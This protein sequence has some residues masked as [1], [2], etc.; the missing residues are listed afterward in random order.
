KQVFG[1]GAAAGPGEG[2]VDLYLS[3]VITGTAFYMSP[4][5]AEGKPVDARSD[6]FAF[7]SVLYEMLTGRRPF[8][9]ETVLA[10]LTS[11]VNAEPE[12]LRSLRPDVPKLLESIFK[13]CTRKQPHERWQN[14]SDVKLI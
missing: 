12:P 13:K 11:I 7:G 1:T 14:L 8:Q 3:G 10:T 4:E 2:G 6:I 5:Q 9:Q